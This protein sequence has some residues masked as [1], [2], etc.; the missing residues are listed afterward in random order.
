MVIWVELGLLRLMGCSFKGRLKGG[1]SR[2]GTILLLDFWPSEK[3][4]L[5]SVWGEAN[6]L[7]L[8]FGSR[9]ESRNALAQGRSLAEIVDGMDWEESAS[10]R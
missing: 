3:G 4:S 5:N 7:F 2:E 1:R 8:S 6:S 9:C 10:P